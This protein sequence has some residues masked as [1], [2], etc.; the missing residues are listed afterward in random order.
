MVGLSG[1]VLSTPGHGEWAAGGV[2]DRELEREK[3]KGKE[4]WGRCGPGEKV[5][6]GEWEDEQ[7]KWTGSAFSWLDS[8]AHLVL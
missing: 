6:K 8:P 2:L 4:K 3:G 5:E 1:Q 7:E